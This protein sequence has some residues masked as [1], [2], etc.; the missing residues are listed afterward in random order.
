ML[1]IELKV[2]VDALGPVR[3]QLNTRNAQFSGRINE[4]DIYYNAP[5]RDFGTTDEALRVRY[6]NDHAVI[7]YKGAKRA[8]YGLKAREELNTAVESG[9]VF[10]QILVRLGFVKTAEVNKWRENYQLENATI[11]LDS[12]DELGTFVEIEVMT[13][14]NGPDATNQINTLAKEMGIVGEPILTSYLELLLSKRSAVRS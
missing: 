14:L 7:T 8:K 12:V 1:E 4:H 11:S 3:E 2:Q 5:H 13:D 6:T 10:E 9:D